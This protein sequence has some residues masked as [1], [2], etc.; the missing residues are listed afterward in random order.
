MRQ[1]MSHTAGFGYGLSGD[2]PV[3]KAFR[4]QRVL[5]SQNLDEMMQKITAIPLLYE[6]GAKWSYSVAV[7]IQGYL[8]QKLSGLKFGDYLKEHVTGPIG[9]GDTAFFVSPDRKA[10][11]TEVYHWDRQQNA[12]VMNTPRTDRGGFEDPT[13]LESGGGGLV[14]S[15]HDYA[16]FCQMML[17]KGE[18]AGTR[19][20]KPE[21][22]KLMSQNHIGPLHV[23]IDGTSPQPGAETVRF[24]LD[25]A[26]YVDPKSANLPFGNGTYYWGGAAGT[27]FWIDPVNDLAFV[28]MIQNQ[29]GNRPGGM[30]FRADSAKLVYAALA[31]P[32]TKTSDR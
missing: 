32:G 20:L 17:N 15:T 10:R 28:G 4:D 21:T 22:V 9:M 14:G 18:I 26:V 29:G 5:G 12:L 11:F 16:R 31:N 24:G 13:R 27:W 3:N 7:D 2:D 19:L 23:G 8:V 30:N 6:P 25:F 1:L